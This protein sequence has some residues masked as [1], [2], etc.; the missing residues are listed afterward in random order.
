MFCSMRIN[1]LHLK[2]YKQF[3]DKSIDFTTGVNVV[4]GWNEKGK[5]TILSSILAVLYFDAKT[6]S[7]KLLD[8]ITSWGG[9]SAPSIELEYENSG[10]NFI[11]RKN[12]ETGIQEVFDVEKS[13]VIATDFESISSIVKE[14]TG[15]GSDHVFVLTALIA[16]N[17][18]ARVGSSIEKAPIKSLREAIDSSLLGGVKADSGEVISKID[19]A[20]TNLDKGLI[21]PVKYPGEIKKLKDKLAELQKTSVEIKDYLSKTVNVS[22]EKDKS[23]DELKIVNEK[24]LKL[25]AQIKNNERLVNAERRLK[26]LNSLILGTEKKIQEIERAKF[27]LDVLQKEFESMNINVD[28]SAVLDELRTNKALL[29][30]KVSKQRDLESEQ[31]D[32]EK[33]IKRQKRKTGNLSKVTVMIGIALTIVLFI[34]FKYNPL[35]LIGGFAVT[36]AAMG[37]ITNTGS[38][39]FVRRQASLEELLDALVFEID[40]L[41]TGREEIFSRNNVSTESELASLNARLTAMNKE[42]S[43]HKARLE[44]LT[45]QS[46]I[47]ELKEQ[48]TTYLAEKADIESNQLNDE[49][50]ASRIDPMESFSKTRELEDLRFSKMDLERNK[51]RADV[52]QETQ[53]FSEDD[54][55]T[56]EEDIYETRTRLSY[57]ENK[58]KTLKTVRD[59]IEKARLDVLEQS[60]SI[61][62]EYAEKLLPRLTDNKYSKIKITDEF[63]FLVYSNDREDWILPDEYLSQGA[64]DQIY[65]VVRLAILK[66]ICKD[67]NPPI[68]L[69]DPLVTFDE[70]RLDG[71]RAVLEEISSSNQVLLLTCHKDYNDWGNLILL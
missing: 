59:Y 31:K 9:S 71:V 11:L 15:I 33:S 25:E 37:I 27:K 10:E 18:I 26:E 46:S 6:K 56:V 3:D 24:I 42:L 53:R 66:I 50:R 68:I 14:H 69:D 61:I 45:E 51:I 19:K 28:I 23:E 44:A 52:V 21:N 13:K 1:R 54:L 12:F 17:D 67:S 47:V 65:L 38:N 34:V 7:K 64:I 29:E 16:Q 32:L 20:I 60:S 40:K 2:N 39:E 22:E 58:S 35:V 70:K 4:Y 49:V 30:E 36:I 63:Q 57:Y 5:S 8:R 55:A 48:E 41:K 62:S 43:E